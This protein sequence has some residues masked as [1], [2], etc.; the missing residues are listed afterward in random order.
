MQAVQKER[1]G[2]RLVL[3]VPPA[4]ES[5]GVKAW[6]EPAAVISYLPERNFAGVPQLDQHHA[7]AADLVTQFAYLRNLAGLE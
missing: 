2:T 4:S 1:P 7:G 3:P 5:G 6:Q